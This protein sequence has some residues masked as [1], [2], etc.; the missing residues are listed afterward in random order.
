MVERGRQ[1]RPKPKSDPGI[2]AAS[3]LVAGEGLAGVLVAA[4]VAA[5]LAP[6]SME[7]RIM[8]IAGELVAL[9]A[10][11]AVCYFLYRS[12]FSREKNQGA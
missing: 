10:I 7:P 3:G 12:G 11:L 2:L 4:L 9:A 1:G 6:R 8:G 5:R